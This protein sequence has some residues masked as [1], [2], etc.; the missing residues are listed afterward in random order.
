MSGLIRGIGNTGMVSLRMVEEYKHR[1]RKR[2]G[3]T[4]VRMFERIT[5][6]HNIGYLSKKLKI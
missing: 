5:R 4:T 2:E 6:H 1:R 3:K